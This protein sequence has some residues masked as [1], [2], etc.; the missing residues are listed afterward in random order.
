[1]TIN[2]FYSTLCDNKQPNMVGYRNMTDEKDFLTVKEYAQL[3]GIHANT[4]RR[5]IK[6]GHLS[7][8]KTGAGKS[9]FRIPRAEIDRLALVNLE[10]IIENK[11]EDKIHG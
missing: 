9:I 11:I 6:N 2:S 1:M 3:L 4:V 10:K 5:S 8:F 7:A